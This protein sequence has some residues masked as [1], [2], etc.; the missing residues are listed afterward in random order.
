MA[1]RNP[2]NFLKDQKTRVKSMQ[3]GAMPKIMQICSV[4][5]FLPVNLG[6][7]TVSPVQFSPVTQSCL[8]LCN[9]MDCSTPGFSIHH[10]LPELIQTHVHQVSDAIQ[11]SHPLSY[12]SPPAFSLSEHQFS[13]V[14]L[15]SSVMS[16][17]L[18]PHESQHA[19]PP[20]PSPTSRVHSDSRPS[21]Q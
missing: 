12:L 18:Q 14:Q 19:R 20:Y 8:T 17:S 9:P 5:I 3:L 10:Q 11:L 1:E 21:S 15:S 6:R 16:D 7:R 4:K 13:S 2:V